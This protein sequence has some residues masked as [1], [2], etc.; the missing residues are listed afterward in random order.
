MRAKPVESRC[1]TAHD[2]GEDRGGCWEGVS[3]RPVSVLWLTGAPGVGKSTVGWALYGLAQAQH[4][5]VAYIDIDQL[6]LIAP[7]PVGDPDYHQLETTNLV[8]VLGTF[9]RHGAEQVIVSGVVDP[10]HGISPYLRDTTDF[11]F[12]LIRLRCTREELQSRYLAR[13][14]SAERVEEAMVVADTLDRNAVGAPLDTTALSP[15]EVV[16]ML[17]DRLRLL[18][19]EV[20]VPGSV[21]ARSAV[22]EQCPVLLL[23]GPTAVGKSTVGW[24]AL[25]MLWGRG[26]TAAY[27]DADQLGFFT[28]DSALKI[29]ADNLIQIWRGYRRAGARALIVVA[30]GTPHPYQHALAGEHVTTVCLQA[31]Q[32]ELAKRIAQRSRGD[33][34]RLAGDSLIAASAQQQQRLLSRSST[35]AAVLQRCHDGAGPSTPSIERVRQ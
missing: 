7:A 27:I 33:G 20:L 8:E 5:L 10:H 26:L 30:R 12:T 32:S 9:R 25:R 3:V 28:A 15:G 13:G 16:G 22:S 23:V 6:G 18:E 14:S 1:R 19:P 21:S 35:E 11:E 34:A 29:K 24:E 4:R 17:A 2:I 31:S